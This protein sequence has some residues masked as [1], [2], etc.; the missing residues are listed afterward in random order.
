MR[1]N[2]KNAGEL[3]GLL[4]IATATKPVLDAKVDFDTK[5]QQVTKDNLG[6]AIPAGKPLLNG[7]GLDALAFL[8]GAP[9]GIV[10]N[11]S[12]S[13]LKNPDGGI[14]FGKS[15]TLSGPVSINHY[16]NSSGQMG[17]T[18]TAETVVAVGTEK[19]QGVPTSPNN[20]NN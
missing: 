15:Y 7:K 18:I 12:L 11:V 20:T 5:V 17:V 1:I 10:P 14:L 8:D 2:T 16:V 9:N 6:D 19:K 4:F 3:D 13:L